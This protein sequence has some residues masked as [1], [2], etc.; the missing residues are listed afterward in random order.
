MT[1]QPRLLGCYAHPD[2]EVLGMAAVFSTEYFALAFP[3]PEPGLRLGSL[4]EGLNV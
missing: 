1:N 4:F 3:E 2:D